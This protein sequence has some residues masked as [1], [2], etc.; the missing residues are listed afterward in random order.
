MSKNLTIGSIA[1]MAGVQTSAV[2]YYEQM[3]LLPTP[4]RV[5]GQRRYDTDVL[6]RLG[7]IQLVREAGFGIRELQILFSDAGAAAP[8]STHWRGLAAGKISELDALIA[9]AQATRA[10]LAEALQS[11]CDGVEDCVAVELNESGDGLSVTLSCLDSS[12]LTMP[13]V[14]KRRAQID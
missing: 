3:G 4:K 6:K 2:R 9:R 12:L 1:R 7:L 11:G 13:D 14:K 8:T 5:N 10:W